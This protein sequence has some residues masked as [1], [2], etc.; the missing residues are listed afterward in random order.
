M[1]GRRH[2]S[3][4]LA[5][6]GWVLEIGRAV[7]AW[8]EVD[9]WPPRGLMSGQARDG[10]RGRSCSQPARS[11]LKVAALS[12]EYR[13]SRGWPIGFGVSWPEEVAGGSRDAIFQ[14][15]HTSTWTPSRRLSH[16]ISHVAFSFDSAVYAS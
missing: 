10:G 8:A 5:A 1:A 11:G 7:C 15:L 2:P 4:T 12:W 6:A 14:G 9:M 16:S 13:T 3:R